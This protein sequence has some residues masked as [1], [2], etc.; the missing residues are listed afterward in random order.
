MKKRYLL[1]LTALLLLVSLAFGGI[2]SGCKT[3]DGDGTGIFEKISV[4]EA[5]SFIQD[6]MTNPDFVILDVRTAEEFN[7]GHIEGAVNIDF[8]ASDFESQ[9]DML[10]KDKV[11]LVYCRSDNRSGQAVD[12]MEDLGFIE[13]YDMSG[14][15][16]AWNDAGYPTVQ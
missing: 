15:I 8:Y 4:A 7:S 6:N 13:A 3:S 12:R 9:L 11:Y 5:Y 10:N 1:A 14:G 16:N 2:L